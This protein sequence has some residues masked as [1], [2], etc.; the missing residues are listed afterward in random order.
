LENIHT[1]TRCFFM[2]LMLVLLF[3]VSFFICLSVT[4]AMNK[5][6]QQTGGLAA[7]EGAFACHGQKHRQIFGGI[8]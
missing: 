7:W 1:V 6:V 2:G 3:L 4:I 8:G 5:R